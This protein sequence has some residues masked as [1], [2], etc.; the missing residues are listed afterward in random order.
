MV[1]LKCYQ[2]AEDIKVN[3]SSIFSI[4]LP[5]RTNFC[6]SVRILLVRILKVIGHV[7]SLVVKTKMQKKEPSVKKALS[8]I[9]ILT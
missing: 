1:S 7:Y 4:S 2:Y 8:K 9:T 5:K 3:I 6:R